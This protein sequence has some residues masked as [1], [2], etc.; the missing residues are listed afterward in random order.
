MAATRSVLGVT[1]ILLCL[2]T[3]SGAV[4]VSILEPIR[5]TGDEIGLIFIPSFYA[6]GYR[7]NLTAQ[8]IQ[9]SSGQRVWVALTENYF[10]DVVSQPELQ[11]GISLAI[12]ELKNAGMTS[13]LYV[14]VVHGISAN[15]VL[16]FVPTSDL[17]ALILMG[18]TL[19]RI[20]FFSGLPDPGT[21]TGCGAG[22]VE[23]INQSGGGIR[24]TPGRSVEP[25]AR[26][27]QDAGT[28]W[29]LIDTGYDLQ[30][31]IRDQEAHR[32]IGKYIN[33]FLTA[34]FSSVDDQVDEALAQLSEAFLKTA[35]KFQPFL[36]I[37]NLET[38]G[39]TSMWTALAQELFAGE[40]SD[41]VEVSNQIVNNL[42]FFSKTPGTTL[43]NDD[44]RIDTYALIVDKD[45]PDENEIWLPEESPSEVNMKLVSKEAIRRALPR[46]NDTTH[47]LAPN[48]CASLNRLALALALSVSTEEARGRYLSRGRPII[49]EEDLLRGSHLGWATSPLEVWEEDD[50]LHVR[51]VEWVSSKQH[52]CKVMSPYRVMEWVNIDSLRVY[53]GSD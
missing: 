27:L 15:L 22:R 37:R 1:L 50:G 25:L 19:F 47:Q 45:K 43:R 42:W 17:K 40:Y 38:D 12:E 5:S 20:N 39:K 29:S 24:E 4:T 10:F 23:K 36:D 46:Q 28:Q 52:Y 14:G 8:A 34:T 35:A 13:E 9:K 11:R 21:N 48:T 41:R 33:A 2:P 51:S 53:Q 6:S 16:D 18:S 7:Y 44:M 31:D 30:P 26:N 3:G 49:V 32:L